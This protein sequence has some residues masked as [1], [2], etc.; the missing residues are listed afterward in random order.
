MAFQYPWGNLQGLNLTW[1]INQFKKLREDWATAEAG[2]EG[3]LDAEIQKAEDALSDVFDARDAAAASATAAAGSAT[4][5]GT[6]ATAAQN[7]ATAAANSATLANTKA[8]AAGVSEANA[9]QSASQAALSASNA[10]NSATQASNSATAAGNSATAAAGSATQAGNSATAAATSETNAAASA[11]EAEDVL[12]SIP[13]DYST[14]ANNVSELQDALD[15]DIITWIDGKCIATNIT[16]GTAVDFTELDAAAY[17]YAVVD[18]AEGDEFYLND[19]LGGGT[20][21]LYA[22]VDADNILLSKSPGSANILEPF[23]LTAPANAV[24]VIFNDHKSPWTGVIYQGV[25]PSYTYYITNKIKMDAANTNAAIMG[26][27]SKIGFIQ[28]SSN[29]PT[30]EIYAQYTY[31]SDRCSTDLKYPVT[32]CNGDVVKCADGFRFYIYRSVVHEDGTINTLYS[33]WKTGSYTIAD[34]GLYYFLCEKVPATTITPT[35]ANNAIWVEHKG[36]RP[37][38]LFTLEK[39]PYSNI[40]WESVRDITSA[41]HVHCTTQEQ[42]ETLQAH[43]D[44]VAISNYYP[45]IPY[46]PLSNYFSNIGNTLASPNAEQSRFT[47]AS[48]NLHMNSLGS[49]LT[50]GNTENNAFDGTSFAMVQQTSK[51]LKNGCGGGVTINHPRWSNLSKETIEDLIN[52]GGVLGIEIWNASCEN[53]NGTGDATALWDSVLSD[54]VQCYGFAVPDHEAQYAPLEN[55]QPF[56]YNHMLVINGTEEEILSAYRMGHFYTTRYNDGLTLEKLSIASGAVTVEVSESSTITFKTA[57]RTVTASGTTASF[58]TQADDVYVRVE[59]SRGT[60]KL[61]SNAIFL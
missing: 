9:A 6:S 7:S 44:H 34:D 39:N 3:S 4:Q 1:F 51:T 13:A 33:G 14:L 54:R 5:A 36:F 58:T 50:A 22:F 12:E 23:V 60:N 29:T 11:Q 21:R 20:P 17:R 40:V 49:F 10:G 32:L 15:A 24:K 59:A 28:G 47:G 37:D 25:P 48:A 35:E 57:S 30:G 56:G 27:G 53:S 61:Y 42:F 18:C 31:R 46:Y 2:I 19:L 26:G 52:H 8:T 41:S 45:A 43:Y 55:R 16:E 38:S